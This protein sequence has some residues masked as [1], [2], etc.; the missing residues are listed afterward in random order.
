[1]YNKVNKV[2]TK[3]I[4]LIIQ[5]GII[6]GRVLTTFL[7]Q[8]TYV[9]RMATYNCLCSNSDKHFSLN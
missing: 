8:H 6:Q 2:I 7:M 3:S 9:R 5:K 4:Y 1:M